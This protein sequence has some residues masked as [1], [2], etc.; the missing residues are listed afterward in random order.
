MFSQE[1]LHYTDPVLAPSSNLAPLHLRDL[2]L[3]H[4][5]S[6]ARRQRLWSQV[7]KVVES[8]SNVRALQVER[9]GEEMRVWE[10]VGVSSGMKEQRRK[11]VRSGSGVSARESNGSGGASELY[12]RL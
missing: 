1:R 8:N 4:E 7:E 12:P 10:W 3:Q 5:H 6:P 9:S 11:G 2:V